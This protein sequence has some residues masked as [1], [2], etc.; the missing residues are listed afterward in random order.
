MKRIA[1][2]FVAGAGLAG[3]IA[4]VALPTGG[5]DLVAAAQAAAQAPAP[6]ARTAWEVRGNTPY[7]PV[8]N[9]PPPKLI[10]DEPLP[11]GLAIGVIWIQYRTE[12]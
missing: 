2:S 3:V 8:K 9:E 7:L 11:D 5:A 12:N 1:L 4:A 6:S 10:V